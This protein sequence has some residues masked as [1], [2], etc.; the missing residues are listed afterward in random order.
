MAQTKKKAVDIIGCVEKRHWSHR[1]GNMLHHRFPNGFSD[2]LMDETDREVSTLTDRAFRS[3]CVGDDAVYNDDFLHGYSPFCCRKPLAGEPLKKVHQKESKKQ[4]KNKKEKEKNLSNMSSFLQA[5]SATEESCEGLLIKNGGI[6]DSNGESWD[7]SALRSIQRELSEFSSDYQTNLTSGQYQKQCGY[8]LSNKTGKGSPLSSGKSSKSKHGKSTIKLKKLNIKNFFLHSELSP[9]QTWRGMRQFSFSHKDTSILPADITPKWYDLPFYKE[10]TQA[11]IKEHTEEILK[12]AGEAAPPPPPPVAPK[13]VSPCSPPKVLPKPTAVQP[14]KRCSSDATDG[15]AAPWRQT[16]AALPIKQEMPPQGKSMMAKIDESDLLMQNETMSLEGKAIEDVSPF[17]STPFSICQLMTPIIP[18]RQPT[19]T[20]EI[21]QAVVSPSVLDLP[22][23]SHSE[24]KLTPELPVKRDG[25][26]SLASSI[27]FNLKDNRKRVKSRYSPPKFKTVDTPGSDTKSPLSD[28]L[29]PQNNSSGL[30]TP[31]VLKEGQESSSPVLESVTVPTPALTKPEADR[32]QSDDYLLSNLLQSKKEAFGN[33]GE[34]NPGSLIM[35]SKKNKSRIAK[36]QNYPS[37]NLYKKISPPVTTDQSNEISHLNPS[38]DIFQKDLSPNTSNNNLGPSRIC[39]PNAL[40]ESNAKGAPLNVSDKPKMP[41]K[42]VKDFGEER[43][44]WGQSMSTMDVIKAARD[45]INATK[46]KVQLAAHS[47]TTSKPDDKETNETFKCSKVEN[48]SIGGEAEQNVI[49]MKDPPPVPKKNFTQ[50]DIQKKIHVSDKLSNGNLAE[51]KIDE[52]A[53]QDKL[54]HI[55]SDRLNNYIKYQRH[56]VTDEQQRDDE[57][58]VNVRTEKD[59]VRDS[60]HIIHDLH[61]LKELERARLCDRENKA[62]VP[63]NIDEE[64]RAKNDLISKELRNIKKGMLSMRGNTSAKREIFSKIQKQPDKQEALARMDGNVMINKALI[65]N[66][67]DKAKMA[68]EEIISDRQMRRIVTDGI[69]GSRVQQ[70]K[71]TLKES[72]TEAK[73]D[74]KEEALRESLGN[75][76]DHKHMRHILSQTELRPGQTHRS[77]GRVALPGMALNSSLRSDFKHAQHRVNDNSEKSEDLNTRQLSGETTVIH[78]TKGIETPTVPPRNKKGGNRRLGSR[79]NGIVEEDPH[80]NETKE[81]VQ[82]NTKD[83]LPNSSNEETSDANMA[84]DA[85]PPKHQL[86]ERSYSLLSEFKTDMETDNPREASSSTVETSLKLDNITTPTD[87]LEKNYNMDAEA[88]SRTMISPELLVN[89]VSVDDHTS[90]SSKSSYFSVESPP[91]KNTELNLYHSLENLNEVGFEDREEHV[92]RH[93]KKDSEGPEREYYSFGEVEGEE[94]I[95]I[96]KESNSSTTDGPVLS[97]DESILTPVSPCDT[98]S[99]TLGIPALFKIK[100]NTFSNKSKKSVQP[101]PTRSLLNKEKEEEDLHLL[102]ENPELPSANETASSG[103]VAEAVK[104][105]E[106]LLNVS[107]PPILQKEKDHGGG[108]SA[109]PKEKVMSAMSEVMDSLTTPQVNVSK[110]PSE[111]S[112]STCSGN[113]SQLGLPKPPAVLPK[114]ERAVLK[115]MKLTNRRMKKEEVHKSTG[116]HKT[117]RRKSDKSEVKSSEKKHHRE[118]DRK[119]VPDDEHSHKK[120]AK[121]RN[122]N[123]VESNHVNYDALLASEQQGRS[124]QIQDKPEQRHYS[125]ISKVPVYKAHVDERPAL[126]TRSQSSDRYLG[127]RVDRRRSADMSFN[128][129]IDLRS[130]RIERSIMDEFQQRGRAREKASREKPLRRS[131][132]I[133]VPPPP[134]TFSRQSSHTSQLSRQ[135]SIEHAIVT[136]AFPMTQRKLLQDPDSGQYYFVDMPVQVKTKTFFDPETGSYVQLPVQPPDGA[137]LQASQME[138]LSPP[139]VVYHSFVPVPLSP[140]AQNIQ[141]PHVEKEELRHLDMSRQ[142]H[143]KD[144]HPYLEPVYGQHE[145]MLGDFLGTEEVDCPS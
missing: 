121:T 98:F 47:E 131:H 41:V 25:Y 76:Q 145:H 96:H 21:I 7:K 106:T 144:G 40:S 29:K 91:H 49:I 74:K 31:A 63:N 130:T 9:F 133:D 32:P 51:T 142:I 126:N 23:R 57:G 123:L 48:N 114:S 61:V 8:D 80:T 89:G 102:N 129:R 84:S 35:H 16:K 39:S 3:L 100:D 4:R 112:A 18:S 134:P 10:L 17:T 138:V 20:S 43:I 50:P 53:Q 24:A 15:S 99:P 105:K 93:I 117:D 67:Y 122:H 75:L 101:W 124:R 95:E 107:P 68:L 12:E 137:V 108:L 69:Y 140:M 45:A 86:N 82:K 127:N 94:D 81:D 113:D 44:S 104:P 27:L 92:L 59:A 115:A 65:N 38:K 139:L 36:M 66:N 73:E 88:N 136:Q 22:R 77:G 64:A 1:A 109:A 79:I 46:N 141:V 5:L 56:S 42:S 19:E 6:A 62:G 11:H 116:K 90:M 72:V 78:E 52:S 26:K 37:L 97:Q 110:V 30:S 132:S 103:S 13:P 128:E 111:R 60:E 71:N 125:G 28:S 119:V 34:E 83:T 55:F 118:G 70:S 54:K 58:D 2:L 87:V 14:Q 143:C 85:V 33:L 135:S 120:T